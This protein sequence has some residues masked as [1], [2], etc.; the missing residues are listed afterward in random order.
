VENLPILFVSTLTVL[1][2]SA[3]PDIVETRWSAS[4]VV[5]KSSTTMIRGSHDAMVTVALPRE[6]ESPVRSLVSSKTACMLLYEFA[7]ANWFASNGWSMTAG[8]GGEQ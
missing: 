5:M 2:N 4:A 1:V 3:L 7:A 8:H 6:C